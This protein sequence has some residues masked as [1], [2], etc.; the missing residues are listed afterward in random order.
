MKR[1]TVVVIIGAMLLSF[2]AGYF[3]GQ[4]G[5]MGRALS[6]PRAGGL[7]PKFADT[8]SIGAV[9][10]SAT[11]TTNQSGTNLQLRVKFR[12]NTTNGLSYFEGIGVFT[13]VFDRRIFR[14]TFRVRK[15]FEG[16][17]ILTNEFVIPFDDYSR[18]Q[19]DLLAMDPG[20]VKLVF[21]V[22]KTVGTNEV[23]A[24]KP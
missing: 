18:G 15:E 17:G 13:D 22:R 23:S 9:F 2:G 10:L 4:K 7:N 21:T 1:G 20:K 19:N 24:A 14:Q 8:N 6:R 11:V 16:R 3:V 12:N 5:G